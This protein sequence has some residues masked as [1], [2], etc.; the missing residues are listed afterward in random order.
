MKKVSSAL[1]AMG[2][3]PSYFSLSCCT[4]HG[5]QGDALAQVLE[6]LPQETR[7]T[8]CHIVRSNLQEP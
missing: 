3:P 2:L 5:G 1:T 7:Y 4:P 8:L 6:H